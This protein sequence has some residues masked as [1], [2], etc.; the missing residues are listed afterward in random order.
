LFVVSSH[1]VLCYARGLVNPCCGEDNASPSLFQRPIFRLVASGHSWVAIFFILLGF[2]NSL[3]PIGLARA[4]KHDVASSKLSAS[5]FSRVLRLI[6]PATIATSFS[7]L[8]CQLGL[9][10]M[11][12]ESDAFW[13]MTN[14]PAPSPNV[15]AAVVDLKTALVD[16]WSLQSDNA[17]D[18]PQWALVHLLQGSF[19]T[20]MVLLMTIRMTPGWRILLVVILAFVSLDW[21]THIGDR[22]SGRSMALSCTDRIPSSGGLYMLYGRGPG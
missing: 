3:K 11:S 19:M 8:L 10:T 9:Y 17:Y 21:S 6:L 12:Q 20:I 22:K 14:T 5:A 18:Q 7:W 2:V 16:T 4:G 15:F 13:L 1:V